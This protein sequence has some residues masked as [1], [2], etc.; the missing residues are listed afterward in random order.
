VCDVLTT[1]E[2][3]SKKTKQGERS[4]ERKPEK[5]VP[6]KQQQQNID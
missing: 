3:L 6:K 1:A 4:H 5:T 2:I